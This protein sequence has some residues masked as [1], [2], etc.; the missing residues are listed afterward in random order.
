MTED[1]PVV[2]AAAA[3]EIANPAYK[4]ST[5]QRAIAEGRLMATD[6]PFL[7]GRRLVT[8]ANVRAMIAAVDEQMPQAPIAPPT[9]IQKPARKPRL[10]KTS[11][12]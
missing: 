2:L 4:V 3:R 5:L 1:R 8:V 12:G 6:D 11:G 10:K 7:P 9:P